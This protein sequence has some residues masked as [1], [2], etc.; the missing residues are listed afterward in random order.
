MVAELPQMITIAA[1]PFSMG[2]PDHERS[3]LAKRH[4]GT[5]ESYAEESPQHTVQLNAFQLAVVPVTNALYASFVG[6]TGSRPPITWSGGQLPPSLHSHPVVDIRWAEAQAFCRWLRA[7]TR[8]PFR[9]PTEAEWE[10]AARG[11]DGRSFPWGDDFDPLCTN[12][13]ESG[14][15]G[16]T[17]VGSYPAGVS[18][19]G[20]LDMAGNVWEWTQ[21]RQAP[22]PYADDERNGLEVEPHA[23]GRWWLPRRRTTPPRIAADLRRILRGGCYANPHGFARCACRFRLPP[24]TSTPFLGLRLA[25]D[26]NS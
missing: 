12:T 15:P 11:T 26:P 9:L 8:T 23:A 5:R 19:Y 24:T 1:G 21:S 6:A 10:K 20:L 13:R 4:G 22:Y 25:A 14:H 18:P 16:T 2:T 7:Q 3:T 17:P